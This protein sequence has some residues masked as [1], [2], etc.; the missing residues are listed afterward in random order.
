MDVI[1]V[2]IGDGEDA[3]EGTT[4]IQEVTYISSDPDTD[5]EVEV[6]YML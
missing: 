3:A 2:D 4:E 6:E 1:D 5:S